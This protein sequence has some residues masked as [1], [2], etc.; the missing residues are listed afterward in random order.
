MCRMQ[1]IFC[2]QAV[3]EMEIPCLQTLVDS[4]KSGELLHS[5]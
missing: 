2:A 4:N 1:L 5:Q 3:A